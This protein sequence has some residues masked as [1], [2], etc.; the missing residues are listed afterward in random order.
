[1]K[2]ITVTALFFAIGISLFGQ[3]KATAE[4]AVDFDLTLKKIYNLVKAGEAHKIDPDKLVVINGTVSVR[5]VLNPDKKNFSG[6]I[7]LNSGEWI[8]TEDIEIYKCYVKL[9]GSE[10]APMIPARRSRHPKPEVIKLNEKIM[11][12]GRYIGYSEDEN[13]NKTPVIQGIKIRKE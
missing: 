2:K 5:E 7:E 10:F 3:T 6:I 11:V 13:G 4:T 12:L 8:G 1:M 9:D